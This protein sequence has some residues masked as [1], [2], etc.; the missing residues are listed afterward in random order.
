MLN[1][2]VKGK[3][4]WAGAALLM[5]G[6]ALQA[7]LFDNTK[8]VSYPTSAN[9][10]EV[11]TI[12]VET[13]FT[14]AYVGSGRLIVGFLAPK[15]WHAGEVGNTVVTYA[16]GKG[17]YDPVG[18]E[19]PMSLIP[20][21]EK[22][23]IA[24]ED[25]EVYGG[26][27]WSQ[28][29]LQK[30]RFGNN[31]NNPDMEWVVFWSN[32]TY[33]I[34]P[35]DRDELE[36]EMKFPVT[37]IIK[38]KVGAQNTLVK[39]G[40]VI[41]ATGL[42]INDKTLNFYAQVFTNCFQVKNGTRPELNY[43]DP[44]IVSTFPPQGDENDLVSINYDL[45]VSRIRFPP[46]GDGKVYLLANAFTKSAPTVAIPPV[47]ATKKPFVKLD[48]FKGRIE[49]W[50]KAYFGI[51]NGEQMDRIEYFLTNSTGSVKLGPIP[52]LTD[53]PYIYISPCK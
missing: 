2:R 24:D 28:A 3:K 34:N 10:G 9:A 41:S 33:R 15:A 5:V 22:P 35:S 38:N 19:Q 48:D 36:T 18:V 50:P 30:S 27:N 40:V 45:T 29:M 25:K 17:Y 31:I 13:S 11:I 47:G 21:D 12:K 46:E 49:I 20:A 26:L 1:I 53:L 42:N 8:L 43:C 14:P 39:L 44:N 6:V 7:C 4:I 37:I 52:D 23:T 32:K 51:P 16:S